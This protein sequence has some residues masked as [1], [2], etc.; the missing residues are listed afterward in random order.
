MVLVIDELARFLDCS[1]R[2]LG[3]HLNIPETRIRILTKFLDRKVR[4]TYLNRDLEK[5]TFL[6]GGLTRKG[7]NKIRAY[8]PLRRP[9]NVSIAQHFYTRHRIQL[10]YPYLNCIIERRFWDK[11][12]FYPIELLEFVDDDEK[13]K[14]LSSEFEEKLS[15]SSPPDSPEIIMDK[16][17]EEEMEMYRGDFSQDGW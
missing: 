7:A 5:K 2:S 17:F 8:G 13:P 15:I 11:D 6:F 4:T 3:G 9:Y 16:E 10:K 14:S 12:R 1:V